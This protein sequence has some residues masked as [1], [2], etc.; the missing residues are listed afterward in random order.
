MEA[1]TTFHRA[2]AR[3]YNINKLTSGMNMRSESQGLKPAFLKM[4]QWGMS[5]RNRI[6]RPKKPEN[7]KKIIE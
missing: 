2:K 5:T 3:K 4:N 1:G 7:K 6:R